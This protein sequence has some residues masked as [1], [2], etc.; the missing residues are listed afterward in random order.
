MRIVLPIGMRIAM[1]IELGWAV[2]I[3]NPTRPP[4]TNVEPDANQAADTRQTQHPRSERHHPQMYANR[5]PNR[6]ANRTPKRS[7]DRNAK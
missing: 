3:Q 5:I 4:R 6:N 2:H 7:T 1:R